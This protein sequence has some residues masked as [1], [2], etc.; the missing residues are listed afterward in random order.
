MRILQV[1]HYSPFGAAGGC[2]NYTLQLS[3]ELAKKHEVVFFYTIPDDHYGE[4]VV[5]NKQGGFTCIAL[6]KDVCNFDR[7]FHERSV[8]VEREFSK[9]LETYKPDVVHFQHLINLSFS[10]PLLAK[11]RGIPACFT[12]HDYWLLCPRIIL[13]APNM[14]ICRGYAPERCLG[15]LKDRT[16]YYAPRST[17]SLPLRLLKQAVKQAINLKKK[18]L[19]HISLQYWRPYQIKKMLGNIDT[20]ISPSRFLLE[21]H[22]ST[23]IAK[24]KICFC[25]LGFNS[26]AFN[27]G[28]KKAADRLRFAFIGNI[29]PYKGI[30]VLIDAFNSIEGPHELKIYGMLDADAKKELER[31]ISNPHI[32]LMGMLKS[33]EKLSAF[34]NM[35]VLIVPSVWYENY[36][37]VINEAF[38]TKTPVIA[39]DLGGMAELVQ[40]GRTGFTFPAGDSESLAEKINIFIKN[41][42]L[43]QSFAA[44]IPPVKD[45]QTHAAELAAIYEKITGHHNESL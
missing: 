32:L 21:Q 19:N 5:I 13:L 1:V 23:I 39:S 42:Y 7:P 18:S 28:E 38:M 11:Q 44:Q 4:K 30:N 40:N 2:E 20:F 16:G 33:A 45:I 29:Q 14:Q 36:P 35:D 6:K 22:T 3:L 12:L 8:W 15:C 27:K 37:V 9:V 24:E 26:L 41:P 31:K 17:G 10:L 43:V 34:S 25:P